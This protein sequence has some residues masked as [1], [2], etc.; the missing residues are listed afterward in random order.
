M[1]SSQAASWARPATLT[2]VAV[3]PLPIPVHTGSG[4]K[5]TIK[6]NDGRN[7]GDDGFTPG[8]VITVSGTAS[9]NGSW[10]IDS[11]SGDTI[12][13]TTS[14]F[15]NAS[16]VTT[17]AT[18]DRAPITKTFDQGTLELTPSKGDVIDMDLDAKL[19]V[20]AKITFD[21][22]LLV[23]NEGSIQ[24]GKPTV[25]GATVTGEVVGESTGPKVIA[26]RFRRR[27]NIRKKRGHR[28][29]FTRVKITGI[30]A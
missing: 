30:Q 23:G 28:Q 14:P 20:G 1:S 25:K 19:E 9:H 21:E 8:M 27:K 7:W 29:H 16:P 15:T 13:L 24:V 5:D 18:V 11:I 10:T 12:T 22:V 26:F 6:R 2:H 17:N 4:A 3:L